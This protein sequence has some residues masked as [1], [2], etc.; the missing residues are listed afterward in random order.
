VTI[1]RAAALVALAASGCL[2]GQGALSD[3]VGV[4]DGGRPLDI[5]GGQLNGGSPGDGGSRFITTVF[6][7]VLENASWKDVVDSGSAPFIN[8]VLLPMAAHAESYRTT[9]HPSEPNYLVMEA[10]DA[11]GVTDD[12]QPSFNHQSTPD[13][14]VN[15]LEAAGV[16]W[17][18]YQ[19]GISG[20]VCPLTGSGQYTPQHNPMVFFDDVT[21]SDSVTSARCIAHVRPF[22]ELWADL[23]A[24]EVTGYNFLTPDLCHDGQAV[25]GDGGILASD[26]WLSEAVPRIMAS[27]A[28]RNG[29]VIFV[30]W[31]EGGASAGCP[32]AGCPIGL[33]AVSLVAKAGHQN[34]IAYSHASLLRTVQTLF[35][36]GP[37]LR[38]AASASPLDD[39]FTHY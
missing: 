35:G 7:I 2:C 24:G 15:Q 28:Y 23:N 10:G 17:R 25:C 11:L 13:H 19:E 21:S 8:T 12:G 22:E 39:L 9:L 36:V 29:G 3:D 26:A 14:L 38:G 6:V 34:S 33:I 27:T 4:P 18:S 32:A 37:Y 20:V 30:T 16:R 1:A 31:D 5:D